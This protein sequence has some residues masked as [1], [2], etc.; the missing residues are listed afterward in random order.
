[1]HESRP[2]SF[3]TTVAESPGYTETIGV[4]FNINAGA[5]LN[6]QSYNSLKFTNSNVVITVKGTMNTYFSGIPVL[7]DYGGMTN[8]YVNVSGGT[9]GY[10]GSAGVA[11]TF[12]VPVY[13]QGGG[14][15]LVSTANGQQ[16]GAKL[17][18]QDKSNFTFPTNSKE[19]VYMTGTTSSVQLRYSATL[20]CDDDYYQANGNLQTMDGTTCSLVDGASS[21][22]TA[23]ITGGALIIDA[24]NPQAYATLNVYCSTLNFAGNYRL[25]INAQAQ[26][27]GSCD[28][29]NVTGTTNLQGASLYVNVNNGPPNNGSSWVII[30]DQTGNIQNGANLA[31]TTNPQTNLN[32]GANGKQYILSF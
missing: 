8:D 7:I 29:I 12:T 17:I 20:E 30:Q 21:N 32:G 28:L 24:P 16:D 25:S 19:S 23:N 6:D 14:V 15:F 31:I 27:A 13:V 22:G 10:Y 9:L 18:V 5:T 11:D 4:Q 1:M 26:G 2:L 3:P